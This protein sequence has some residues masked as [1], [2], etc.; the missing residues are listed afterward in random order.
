MNSAIGCTAMW[1]GT[2]EMR[3]RAE[4]AQKRAIAHFPDIQQQKL[5]VGE[6]TLYWWGRNSL[7]DC[8]FTLPDGSVLMVAGSPVGDIPLA[9][10]AKQMDQRSRPEEYRIPWE[11]RFILLHVSA[12]GRDWRMWNDWV[13]SIPVF[14]T[15]SKQARIASTLE[16]VV[17]AANRFTREDFFWPGIV[18]LLL[19]GHLLWDWTL[20]KDMK[21][22]LPDTVMAWQADNCRVQHCQTVEA[23]EDY[24]QTGYDELV[25]RMYDLSKQAIT[26]ALENHR[27]WVV[28]L[29]GGLDSR[30]I[31]AAGSE[32]RRDLHAFTWGP[33]T[34]RD[35]V[36]A[37][38]VAR[39][40]GLPWR[41]IDLKRDYL[42]HYLPLWADLFGSGMHFHGMYQVQFLDSIQAFQPAPIITGNYGDILAGYFTIFT[43]DID[44]H[45]KRATSIVPPEFLH[46]NE[47]SLRSLFKID[48]QNALDQIADELDRQFEAS[49][50]AYFQRINLLNIRNR[51]R[52][53]ISFQSTLADYWRGTATP[54]M[55]RAYAQFCFSLPKAVLENRRL[56]IDML[57]R[58][59]PK[60]MAIPGTYAPEPA[61]LTGRYLLKRRAAKKLPPRLGSRLLPEFFAQKSLESDVASL[62]H[63]C[64]KGIW[65]IPEMKNALSEWIHYDRVIPVYHA[66]LNGDMTS[67]RRL[68]SLQAFSYR[69]MDLG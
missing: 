27:T 61:I 38:S 46:W 24:W 59:Y 22:V 32:A 18:F 23:N 67:M 25:E 69:L 44:F 63:C 5:Q 49:Q 62:A 7:A 33:A 66:A 8:V 60:V 12:D 14:Y 43:E 45:E 55:D 30:L 54:Y 52:M 21:T 48:I 19:N 3:L 64:E 15:Q 50:G 2:E 39:V 35:A 40:L 20:F 4:A 6:T 1:R 34:T 65:P 17:V 29:S 13:G 37:R 31:A 56:E 36:N 16:P 51:Q 68:Q 11:G 42:S 41:R 47:E 9:E 10:I 57:K 26:R 53:F 28:P 58:Y